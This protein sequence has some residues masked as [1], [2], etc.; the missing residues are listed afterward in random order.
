[1]SSASAGTF[2]V[3]NISGTSLKLD[4]TDFFNGLDGS[5]DFENLDNSGRPIYTRSI[6][7]SQSKMESKLYWNEEL[8]AWILSFNAYN[9]SLEQADLRPYQYIAYSNASSPV[10]INNWRACFPEKSASNIQITQI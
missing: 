10:N 4:Q 5:Y 6:Q 9:F 7:S 2:P 1:M 8:Q 3:I